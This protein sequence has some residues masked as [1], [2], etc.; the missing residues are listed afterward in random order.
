MSLLTA[1]KFLTIIPLPYRRGDR[2]EEIGR[3]VVYFPVV[4]LL[5]GLALAGLNWLLGLFLPA[6]IVNA[7]LIAALVGISGALHL[8]GFVDTCDGLGGHKPAEKRWEVMRD[9]RVG[10]FGVVGVVLLLLVKFAALNNIPPALFTAGLIIMPVLSR[11]AMVYALFAY[12]YARDEG[13]GKEIKQAVNRLRFS[14]ATV[15]T[16]AIVIGAGWWQGIASYVPAGL[17]LMAAVW[18]IIILM[19]AYFKKMFSGLTGDTYG[20]I[21]EAAEVWVLILITALAYNQ[22][23]V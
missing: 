5:I 12:S 11:W 10:A 13:L 20:A 4:G 6:G 16:L 17:A 2:P 23:L 22:W 3:S 9:S 14:L 18:V 15:L 19:A 8:D 1:L 7:L 21:N